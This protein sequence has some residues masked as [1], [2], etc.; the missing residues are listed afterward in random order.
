MI[1]NQHN[2]HCTR[3]VEQWQCVLLRDVRPF[4]LPSPR[5]PAPHRRPWGRGGPRRTAT[6]FL[7]GAPP[8]RG[9]GDEGAFEADIRA[10]FWNTLNPV[11][12]SWN[13]KGSFT[14]GRL[15]GN[16]YRKLERRS[17]DRW[18][19]AP[20]NSLTR[21]DRHRR[22]D[23]QGQE[24]QGLG[25]GGATPPHTRTTW[26]RLSSGGPR[27]DRGRLISQRRTPFL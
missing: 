23:L 22:R 19:S 18:R 24:V 5:I 17:A 27:H 1:V 2:P 15:T 20:S 7:P 21:T 6:A 3:R 11:S 13:G 16:D 9:V 14:S 12:K 4:L 25:R 26:N 10:T 8:P